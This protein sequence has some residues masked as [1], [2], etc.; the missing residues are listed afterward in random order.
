VH[1]FSAPEHREALELEWERGL[2]RLID[3]AAPGSDS[4]LTFVR[5]Y[6][7]AAHTDAALDDLVGL[8]DGSLVIDGLAV[9]QD[10]RWVLVTGLARAG[11]YGEAEIAAE[12][13]RDNTITGH[14]NAAAARA[15]QPL[16]EAKA[17]AWDAAVLSSNTPNET[18]R[19]IVLAF[20]QHGQDEVLAP[21]LDKYLEAAEDMWER[22]GTHKAS[23]ALEYIFPKPLASQALLYRVDSWLESSSANPAAKRYVREGRAD[24]ARFLAGQARDAQQ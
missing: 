8:L 12:S 18:Q 6:A 22:L 1:N 20:A 3:E 2:R 17:T 9:D 16:A 19:S 11:R 10:L 24:V 4:Q 7:S 21:Y 15:A 23:V 14:E 13:E 5:S